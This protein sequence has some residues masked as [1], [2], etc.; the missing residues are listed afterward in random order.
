[1][2]R[3]DCEVIDRFAMAF[4]AVTDTAFSIAMPYNSS[5]VVTLSAAGRI[6]SV[7]NFTE[8]KTWFLNRISDGTATATLISSSGDNQFTPYISTGLVS[9]VAS[10]HVSL[11]ARYQVAAKVVGIGS[12][13]TGIPS[14]PTYLRAD[15]TSPG[16]IANM[17]DHQSTH[18]ATVELSSANLL[19]LTTPITL[20]AAQGADTLIEF[21]SALLIHDAGTAYAEPSAPDDMVIQY[22]T[23][24]SDV[25]AS[26]DA[27]GFLT[28]T[29][30]EIRLVPSN[31]AL[32][33]DLLTEK[34]KALEIINTGSNY[35]TGTGT[36][37]VKVTYRVHTLGL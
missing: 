28:T 3:A 37:T 8:Q 27:T 36:M 17:V 25:S 23:T 10:G 9:I 32:T 2:R 1:M 12:T 5:F 6:T 21:V 15:S 30:D 16:T 26:I 13:S 7:N 22:N 31:L 29:T 35:T 18:T 24:G 33:F 11:D 19:A 20:V 4:T 34:N 14:V